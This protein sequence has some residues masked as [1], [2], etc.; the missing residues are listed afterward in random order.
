MTNAMFLNANLSKNL[1]GEAL[2]TACHVHNMIPSKKFKISPYDIWNGRKPYLNYLRVWGCLAF[3][4]ISD[5]NR[6]KLG[7]RA[8]K[9]VFVGYAENSKAYRLL[10]LDS[11]VIIESRDVK[12]FKNK[13]TRDSIVVKPTQVPRVD[14]T[15]ETNNK[16]AL[17]DAP[18]ELRRSRRPRK[19]KK[20]DP[21]FLYF[22]VEGDRNIV[23]NKI[24]ILLIVEG[25]PK[26]FSEAMTSRDVAFWKEADNDEMDSLLANN[27]WVLTDLAPG[28][29]AI[30]CK[31]IF[32]R[33]DNTDGSIQTF[34]ARLIAKGFK[35]KEGVDYFD[36]YAPIA[37]IASIRVLL[38][39]ASIY[40]LNVHQMD[41]KMTFLN[42]DLSEEVYMEQPEGFVLPG[43]ENKTRHRLCSFKLSRFTNNPSIE[44]WKGIRRVFGYFKGTVNLGLFYNRFPAVLEGYSDASWIT[45]IENNKSTSGWI[46]SLA[47]GA[48]A[49]AS[50]KQTCSTHSTMKAEFVALAAASKEAEW[51]R[52]LLLDI[53]LWPQPMPAISLL[54]DSEA[55]MS[56]A[57]NKLYKG[58]K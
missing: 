32:R 8:I 41:V 40:K 18:T 31:W 57:L 42:G 12:F 43:N 38:A 29:K 3:Y 52:N 51:L 20:L 7:P 54:C 56:R 13:F 4:R 58:K 34:K 46:F 1:W 9:S 19:A 16:R 17:I 36:T 55:A 2:L 47:G 15:F 14:P 53:K 50:K 24:P 25:D 6:T 39:L 49:W 45:S 27:T 48:V 11:N 22:I 44:H 37:R 23:L 30:G 35:Q 28:S 10:D 5:P 33:K 26:T 21:D